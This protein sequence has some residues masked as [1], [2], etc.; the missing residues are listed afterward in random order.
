VRAALFTYAI[1]LASGLT[2]AALLAAPRAYRN[3]A[4]ILVAIKLA[5]YRATGSPVFPAIHALLPAVIIVIAVTAGFTMQDIGPG[6]AGMALGSA[7]CVLWTR[8]PRPGQT[9]ARA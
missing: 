9:S 7:V 6:A 5:V 4:E 2:V 1:G 8:T 3:R